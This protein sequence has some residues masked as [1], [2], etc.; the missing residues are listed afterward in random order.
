MENAAKVRIKRQIAK[1]SLQKMQTPLIF[2]A[3]LGSFTHYCKASPTMVLQNLRV[4]VPMNVR[5]AM[6]MNPIW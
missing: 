5:P 6:G 4:N 1:R 2:V 3:K